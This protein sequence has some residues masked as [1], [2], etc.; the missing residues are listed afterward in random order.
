MLLMVGNEEFYHAKTRRRKV[1]VRCLF[2]SFAFFVALREGVCR[3]G[4]TCF[5]GGL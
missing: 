4:D 2:L 5:L 3:G 1:V